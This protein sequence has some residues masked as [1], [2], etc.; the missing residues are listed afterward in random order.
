MLV[1]RRVNEGASEERLMAPRGQC[2]VLSL[3]PLRIG[4]LANAQWPVIEQ[5]K[6]FLGESFQGSELVSGC[7]KPKLFRNR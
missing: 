3:P 7:V 6:T 1:T 2:R 5:L 4:L